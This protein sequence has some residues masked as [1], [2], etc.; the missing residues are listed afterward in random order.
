M[1]NASKALL[2]AGGVLIALLVITLAVFVF[3][4]MSDYQKSQSDLVEVE[5]L[6]D[7]NEQFTQYVRN[8]LNGIDLVTLANKVVNFNQKDS[9]A[10]EINYDQ[11]ITLIINMENY[12]QKYVGNLFDKSTYTVENKNSDFFTIISK[13]TELE[14]KY[15]LKTITALSSNIESLKSYY[16]NNDTIN[17]KSVSDVTGRKVV[18]G[19]DLE[20][21]ENKLKNKDFSDI[22]RYSEYSEFKTAEFEGLQ[23]EYINGQISKLTFKYIGN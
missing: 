10:G 12:Q 19:S 14:T 20:T 18:A 15:T 1:D 13:Y 16:I 5:Q 11:D 17:G 21:L 23:P 6:A 2:M 4:Q 22:E 7:F 8:D 9:G 3:N